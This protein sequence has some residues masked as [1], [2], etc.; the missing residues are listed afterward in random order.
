MPHD[1]PVSRGDVIGN[2][3]EIVDEIGEGGFSVVWKGEDLQTGDELVVKHPNFGSGKSSTS[4][5]KYFDREIEALDQI[6]RNGGHKNIMAL[7]DVV[8]ER[9][10]PFMITEFIDGEELEDRGGMSDYDLVRRVTSQLCDVFGFL[11]DIELYYRDLKPDNAMLTTTDDVKL[12]DFNTARKKMKCGNRSCQYT[13]R[14]DD[15]ERENCPVC[16][17][18]FDSGSVIM[19]DRRSPYKPHEVKSPHGR[20]GPWSDVYSLGKILYYLITDSVSPN[21]N[22]DP[23]SRAPNCPD[24]LAEIC[25]RATEVE[26]TRRY[27]N[28]GIMKLALDQRTA[29]PDVPEAL[30]RNLNTGTEYT[31]QPGDTIGCQN[32]MGPYAS[33]EVDDPTQGHMSRVHA[34]FE[35]RGSTWVLVDMSLNGTEIDTGFVDPKLII[36]PESWTGRPENAPPRMHEL[37]DG[38]VVGVPRIGQGAEFE[39]SLR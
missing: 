25:T 8:E 5:V 26:A 37:S 12:I 15:I 10:T 28:A 14:P 22:L 17:N 29:Y 6:G 36:D 21:D 11:H 23:Q 27:R 38:D 3:Y 24:Y 9:Q 13:I 20:Q 19:T 1:A 32:A 33:F 34:K 4:L 7:Y 39:F 30:I 16:G 18:E 31:I 35:L 2:R